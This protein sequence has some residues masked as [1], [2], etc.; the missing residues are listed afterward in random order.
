MKRIGVLLCLLFC[1]GILTDRLITH[2][3][4]GNRH[5][6][7]ATPANVDSSTSASASPTAS[8]NGTLATQASAAPVTSTNG[9]LATP[10][11]VTPPANGS[12][13]NPQPVL[14]TYAGKG[15]P[16]I[17]TDPAAKPEPP[18]NPQLTLATHSEAAPTNPADPKQAE[19]RHHHTN[20]LVLSKLTLTA[21]SDLSHITF[22]YHMIP[23]SGNAD[24]GIQLFAHRDDVKTEDKWEGINPVDS[25]GRSVILSLYQGIDNTGT[26]D[27]A[28]PKGVYGATRLILFAAPDGKNMDMSKTL[29]DT[30][31]D[32]NAHLNLNLT[33]VSSDKRVTSPVM[34]MVPKAEVTT[35]NN[36]GYSATFLG[37]V[38]VPQDYHP[39]DNGLWVMAKS[40]CGFVQDWISMNN[41]RPAG[42]ANDNYLKIPVRLTIK[43]VKTGLWNVQ[44]GLFKNSWG[45]PLTWVYPGV[46]FAAGDWVQ[47]A[48]ADHLPPRLQVH[49]NRFQAV[50]GKPYDFYADRATGKQAVSFVRG[51]NYGNA[52]GWTINP[53]YNRPGYFVLLKQLG[54]HFMR[55]AFNPERFVSEAVYRDAVDQIVQNMWSAGLYPVIGPQG[56]I[57]A[58][59]L[60]EQVDKSVKLVELMASH[61]KGK[62]IW[63]EVCN[64]PFEVPE[65][66]KWKPIASRMARAAREIDPDAFLIVPLE[67]WGKDGR[68]AAKDPIKDVHVDLYDAHAYIPPQDVARVYSD[69]VKAGLPLYIG[70]YGGNDA[71]YLSHMDM[72]LQNLHGLVASAPWAFT[73]SGQD[74]L[75]LIADGSTAVLH[76]TPTGQQIA[77][78]YALWDQGKRKM[79]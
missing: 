23:T 48:P 26:F 54:C 34:L 11:S 5:F 30:S 71:G 32:P 28:L 73:K 66:S 37:I 40:P 19:P 45:D 76:F 56:L 31:H 46:D 50:D 1:L 64:E 75:P 59:T 44:F 14:Y 70:E 74:S 51:G 10:V 61:Y 53:E 49:N 16:S 22:T 12:Q 79:Q 65:W 20:L 47:K 77:T 18:I 25:A 6:A 62:P 35:Q 17:K 72:A 68:A 78:D 69:A 60:Q 52:I 39:G 43:N 21:K 42:D 36:G 13:G 27:V 3:Q 8:A 55:I 4:S 41:A 67:G 57:K 7:S 24:V 29:Y 2:L 33:V 58:T 9:T 63:L 15:D 38:K